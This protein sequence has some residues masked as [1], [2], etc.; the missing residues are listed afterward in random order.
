[1]LGSVLLKHCREKGIEAVGTSRL[2][3]DVCDVD[4]LERVAL[5]ECPTHVVNCAAYTDVDGAESNSEAA[6]AVNCRGAANVGAV[7]RKIKARLVH[8]ST[9]Y[10]FDGKG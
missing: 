3:A 9:D 5:R 7:V 2:E 6:F 1:M 4:Q 10:V 8:I